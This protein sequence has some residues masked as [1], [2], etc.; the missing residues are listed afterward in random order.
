MSRTLPAWFLGIVLFAVTR[1]RRRR[2]RRAASNAGSRTLQ[3]DAHLD[4]DGAHPARSIVASAPNESRAHRILA[5]ALWIDVI[6]RRGAVTVD[7]YLG[8]IGKSDVTMPKPPPAL[9][10]EFKQEVGRAIDLANAR[11]TAHPGDLQA[12]Y[13]LGSAY[14]L[15]ASYLASVEGKMTSAFLSAR[16]AFDAQEDVLNRDPKRVGAGV[17]VGTY[18]YLVAGLAL[19][20][21]M[22][23]YMMGFGGDKERAINLLQAATRDP[24]A[25]VE[26]KLALILILVRGPACR[27]YA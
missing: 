10:T 24:S 25:E 21:R 9:D 5:V 15:Q 8:N 6:F 20:S 1:I 11:L 2:A 16:R 27:R 14:G 23:A 19:P 17:V 18:R 22:I 7:H 3:G 13:D 4:Q 26:A 12:K